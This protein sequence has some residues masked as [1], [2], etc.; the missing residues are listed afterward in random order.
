MASLPSLTEEAKPV[1]QRLE[2]ETGTPT[3]HDR[4]EG[5]DKK[6]NTESSLKD[7]GIVCGVEINL[8]QEGTQ[9]GPLQSR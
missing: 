9:G 7:L 8:L 1:F 5:S 2:F 3:S 4:D 6:R